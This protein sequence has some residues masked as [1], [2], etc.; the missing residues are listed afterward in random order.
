[1][2]VGGIRV[3]ANLGAKPSVGI[4]LMCVRREKGMGVQA[5]LLL[6]GSRMYAASGGGFDCLSDL[7]GMK[8]L[9]SCGQLGREWSCV[10]TDAAVSPE[11]LLPGTRPPV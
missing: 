5:P 1:M 8:D 3:K 4:N 9:S 7:L 2:R 11:R 6:V 10:G